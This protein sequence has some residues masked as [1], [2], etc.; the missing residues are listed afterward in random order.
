MKIREED[1]PGTETT[2]G[3]EHTDRTECY[4]TEDGDLGPWRV[5]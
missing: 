3:R 1:L 5:V 4:E 2:N